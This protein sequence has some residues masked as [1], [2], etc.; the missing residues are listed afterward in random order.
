MQVTSHTATVVID[1]EIYEVEFETTEL[2]RGH[3]WEPHIPAEPGD[4]WVSR[5]MH[6]TLHSEPFEP[7]ETLAE[8]ILDK[9]EDVTW[10]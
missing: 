1:G 9:L 6:V 10:Q 7:D 8:R 3:W 2:E 5:L 4:V